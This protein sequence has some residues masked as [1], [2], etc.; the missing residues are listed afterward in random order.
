MCL[1]IYMEAGFLLCFL[2]YYIK[3]FIDFA[4]CLDIQFKVLV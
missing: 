2:L 1:F 4:K 3:Y